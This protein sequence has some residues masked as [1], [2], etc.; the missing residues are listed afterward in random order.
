VAY[1][2]LYGLEWWAST[3][4][5]IELQGV[6]ERRCSGWLALAYNARFCRDQVQRV[7]EEAVAANDAFGEMRAR[8]VELTGLM[9]WG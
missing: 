1:G 8:M 2:L 9:W 5:L 4:N 6:A 3:E 7:A